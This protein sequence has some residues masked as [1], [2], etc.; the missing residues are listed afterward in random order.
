MAG[1][2]WVGCSGWSYAH[3]REPVYHRAPQSQ[4]LA[5]YAQL[6]D[7]VE[8]N[9]SFYRLPSRRMVAG[10]AEHSPDG[11]VFAVKISRYLTHVRRLRDVRSGCRRLLER[12]EPLI[13]AGKLGPLLW[14]LPESFHRDDDRL[15]AALAEFPEQFRN[16]VEFR[17]PSWFCP[18]V[19]QLLEDAGVAL[20][21]GDH[22][23]RPFQRIVRTADWAYIR[24]HYGSAGRRGNYSSRELE[25]WAERVRPWLRQG[26]VFIYF[27][28][29]W[30]VFAVRNALE[31][32]R[33]LQSR[34]QT[35][36]TPPRRRGQRRGGVSLA[37]G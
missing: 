32:A 17:H 33:D 27:N 15:A 34:S 14:Q 8:V 12:L 3:W 24:F 25:R 6:F 10:W 23:Q 1:R 11:F 36:R 30:E 28:N 19:M 5:R 9:T 31:L 13:E 20:V 22:P 21:V 29:D 7:T 26:D 18:P 16:A 2:L 4:W 35:A 37:R